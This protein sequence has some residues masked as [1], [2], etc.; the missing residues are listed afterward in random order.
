MLLPHVP[1]GRQRCEVHALTDEEWDE[2]WSRARDATFFHGRAWAEIWQ[3]YSGGRLRPAPLRLRLASG[4]QAIVPLVVSRRFPSRWRSRYQSM[5]PGTYGGWFS[6]EP[7]SGES[8]ARFTEVLLRDA[9]PLLVRANPF[10]AV[11]CQALAL[12]GVT[13]RLPRSIVQVRR[14]DD[15][16][17]AVRLGAD[18]EELWRNWRKGHRSA[19]TKARREGV[20]TRLASSPGDWKAY[21][22]MYEQ[23][24]ERWGE[25]ATS[26]YEWRLFDLI[27]RANSA[28]VRLWLAE[29]GG[30]VVAGALCFYSAGNVSY[31]HGAARR[32]VQELRA[33]HLLLYDVMADACARGLGWFDFNP[34]GGHDGVEAFKLGFRP[35]SLACPVLTTEWPWSR[36][37]AVARRLARRVI[38]R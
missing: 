4:A 12:A 28:H 23:A 34:S 3:Q 14:R 2:S 31:W 5:P 21:H 29:H 35:E 6:P 8:A 36:P 11:Q 25:A 19:V 16:T 17:L 10:D 37:A 9:A 1:P 7:I 20:T 38:H 33:V 22:A 30:E 24:L 26:R 13:P 27:A 18:P 32:E 15:T